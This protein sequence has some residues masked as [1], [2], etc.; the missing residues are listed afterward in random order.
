MYNVISCSRSTLTPGSRLGRL[1]CAHSKTHIEIMACQE[2]AL[3][4]SVSNLSTSRPTKVALLANHYDLSLNPFQRNVNSIYAQKTWKSTFP[5]LLARECSFPASTII[6]TSGV[7]NVTL[8]S[9]CPIQMQWLEFQ[10]KQLMRKGIY[11][12]RD[13]MPSLTGRKSSAIGI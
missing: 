1:R 2:L 4:S 9:V 7:Q 3:D 12:E 8:S 6:C 10:C 13:A 5:N 11:E